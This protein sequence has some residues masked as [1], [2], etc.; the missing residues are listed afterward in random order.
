[1]GKA[2]LCFICIFLPFFVSAQLPVFQIA[3][4]VTSP[5]EE[6]EV[7]IELQH[8]RGILGTQFSM[9]WDSSVLEFVA[10]RN[11][12][13]EATEQSNF[14]TMMTENGRLSYRVDDPSLQ[15]FELA[16]GSSLFTIRFRAIGEIGDSSTIRF[17][18]I[19]TVMEVADTS[20]R[21]VEATFLPGKV[22]ISEASSLEELENGA[23]RITAYPNPFTETTRVSWYQ[24]RRATVT[25]QIH[26][27]AGQRVRSGQLNVGSGRQE[28]TIRSADLPGTG[29]YFIHL[30]TDED[31]TLTR[32]LICV[33]S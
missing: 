3:E 27:V 29:T 11:L 9:E 6:L 17:G 19:P 25:Y 30:Q 26:N 24:H 1:M 15:G 4:Y 7:D 28:L 14:N 8:Y 33:G 20:G 22:V 31:T 21:A 10:L 12:A 18:N 13:L 23:L 5:G 16:D 2:L 32:K